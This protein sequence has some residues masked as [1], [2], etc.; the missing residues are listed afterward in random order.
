M[1]IKYMNL[2]WQ[3][4]TSKGAELLLLLAIADNANEDGYAFPGITYLSHKCRMSERHVK[5]MISE[6][7]KTG[8]LEVI[9]VGRRNEYR[10]HIGDKLAL[11]ESGKGTSESPVL[12]N[13]Q[14][15]IKPLKES[16]KS[17]DERIDHPTIKAYRELAHYQVPVA[18]RDDVINTIGVAPIELGFWCAIIK[19]W[20][21]RGYNPRNISGMLNVYKQRGFNNGYKNKVVKEVDGYDEATDPEVIEKARQKI[22][23]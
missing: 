8:E 1:S 5:R 19:E 13:R 20:I 22:K 14:S 2:V 18:I 4:S 11:V 10:I 21:G 12:I 6:L 9:K 23:K 16:P 7:V 3:N 15:L 17:R